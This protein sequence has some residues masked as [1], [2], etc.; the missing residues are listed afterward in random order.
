MQVLPQLK[1]FSCLCDHHRCRDLVQ[2]V[3]RTGV[4]APATSGTIRVLARRAKLLDDGN[5]DD[6]VFYK[7][8]SGAVYTYKILSD[9]RRQITDLHFESEYFGLE[10]GDRQSFL[11][12]AVVDT[13]LSVIARDRLEL[14]CPSDAEFRYQVSSDTIRRLERAQ[15]HILLLGRTTAQERVA[16][17]LLDM[18]ARFSTKDHLHLP[19]SRSDIADFLGLTIETVSRTLTH[20]S[21]EGV[22]GL[23][24]NG[25]SIF[26][27]KKKALQR[28]AV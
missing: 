9:G 5:D 11:A 2:C 1:S 7:V 3:C 23:A 10:T 22:I 6:D 21:R 19:M 26:L 16:T 25:R 4:T 15:R 27:L 20:L 17:F 18:A 24:K 12:H 28:L 13:R 8:D 14:P